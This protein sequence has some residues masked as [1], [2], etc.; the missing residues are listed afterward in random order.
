MLSKFLKLESQFNLPL[1]IITCI[2]LIR[3]IFIGIMGPM[4]Q[5]AYYYFYSEHP[6]LSY[7]DH[8]PA[9][10]YILRLFTTIFGEHVASIKL[11]DSTVT[12]LTV[13]FFYQLSSRFY[14]KKNT[15]KSVLLLMSTL[16]VTILSLVSTPDTPLLLCW[17]LSLILLHKA[18]FKSNKMNWIWAGLLM[19]L[20]FDSKYT[21]VFLPAGTLLFLLLSKQHRTLLL[22]IWPWLACLIFLITALPV[23]IWNFGNNF[24]SFRFQGA[25]RMHTVSSFQLQPKLFFGL[26]GHQ[27]AILIPVM[28]I[29]IFYGLYRIAKEYQNRWATLPEK[30]IFLLSF[31]LPLFLVFLVLSFI[32]WVKLNWMMPAYITGIILVSHYISEKWMKWQL[33]ISLVI[34]LAL[35]I[36]ILYYPFPIKSDDT[37]MGWKELASHVH[38]LQKDENVDFIFSADGYKTSAELNLYLSKFVYAQNI[39]GENALQFDYI[40]TNLKALHGKDALYIDSDPRFKNDLG[41]GQTP[42][43]VASYFKSVKELAPIVIKNDGI[44]V[45]KFFVYLCRDYKPK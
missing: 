40:G 24:A 12:L 38:Q 22:T 37:W 7:F 34:H 5:D 2:L 23:I 35:A 25:E 1:I 6:A 10:A 16:M 36:E 42:L 44:T 27:L 18:I 4:P 11:A 28:F 39:I 45:R 32:Y 21:A 8:P 19:G 43:K 26:L 41:S 9:I 13:Y 31:F 29:S 33:S 14:D 17:T 30:T 3:I 15:V 20:A